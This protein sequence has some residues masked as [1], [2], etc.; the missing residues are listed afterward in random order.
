M[1]TIILIFLTVVLQHYPLV[2]LSSIN[3][4][5]SCLFTGHLFFNRGWQMTL[6]LHQLCRCEAE[7]SQVPVVT[8]LFAHSA[9]LFRYPC[10]QCQWLW[11][12]AFPLSQSAVAQYRSC[13]LSIDENIMALFS[14]EVQLS[15]GSILTCSWADLPGLQSRIWSTDIWTCLY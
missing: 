9:Y 14:R 11:P 1:C 3:P 12:A 4:H 15:F 2:F 8:F 10:K 7:S 5:Q 6:C 13:C